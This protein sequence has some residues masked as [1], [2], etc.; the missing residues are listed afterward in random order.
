MIITCPACATRYDVDDD[1][2]QPDGRSVRCA[3][4][5]E[6]WFVP[7]PTPVENL[8]ALKPKARKA[9]EPRDEPASRR[10]G[11][12]RFDDAYEEE[13]DEP[14]FAE[15]MKP[16]RRTET[17]AEPEPRRDA[18]S[19]R[20]AYKPVRDVDVEDDDAVGARK[21][22]STREEEP[23]AR[24]DDR[25]RDAV[26]DG[27][28]QGPPRA[29]RS[30][31]VVDADFEDI[32]GEHDRREA[33]TLGRGFG[34]KLHD[35]RAEREDRRST[36]LARYEDL[37]PIAERVFNEEFFAALRVQP[38]ELERAIRKARRRA[39]ARDKNRLTPLRALGWS[40]FAGAIAAAGFVAYSYRNDI[41][42]MVPSALGAYEAIGIEARPFGLEIEGVTHRVA[43]SPQGPVIE[44]LGRL[45]NAGAGAVS[46]PMLQAEAV[47]ADGK[48]LSRW[49]FSAR[50]GEVAPGESVDFSTRAGAPEGVSEVLLSFAPAEG[51]KVSVGQI[52]KSS[53]PD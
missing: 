27:D 38:K 33:A 2:F 52:L 12:A 53:S 23:A 11:R 30:A 15:A 1:R 5:A 45:K 50:E 21:R 10:D 34:R 25:R 39:E 14:L 4:C 35:E 48:I 13:V 19:T 37:E 29:R 17:G 42:A 46:A 3:E 16:A 40:A 43:M 6:S 47:G 32:D 24:R 8:M 18:R 22:A 9:D 49:T 20:S 44:I 51:V 41:V 26:D 31:K 28:D 7:A 36:A